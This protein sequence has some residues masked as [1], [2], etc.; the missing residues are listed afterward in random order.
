MATSSKSHGRTGKLIWGALFLGGALFSFRFVSSHLDSTEHESLESAHQRHQARVVEELNKSAAAPAA[1]LEYVEPK[2]AV[3]QGVA[4]SNISKNLN[5]TDKRKWTELHQIL[6]S[7]D[8][9]DPRIDRDFHRMSPELH[10]ALHR[11][12]QAIPIEKRNERGLI[13][14]L[15]ARD[16]QS[17]QDME[18]LKDVYLE[19]PCLSMEN[20]GS[21]SLS[22][23]HL[24]GVDQASMN[25]PQLI[26]LYQIEKQ[27]TEHPER[28]ENSKFRDHARAVLDQASRYPV[29]MVQ[30]KADEVRNKLKL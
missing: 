24:S 26:A 12:Y 27:L 16:M 10:G 1:Q 18:F 17:I 9:N 30:K 3:A 19:N 8:D 28:L 29:P 14:F 6:A 13:A 23:P 21:R 7:K 4:N 20:C 2:A 25:Y 22:D 5:E 15:I 11:Q